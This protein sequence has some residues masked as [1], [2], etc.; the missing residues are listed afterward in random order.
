M[1]HKLRVPDE[2]AQVIGNLHPA[3]KRKVRAA[4]QA[5][6]EEPACGKAL[7][8]ELAGLRSYRFGRF[9]F[10]YRVAADRMVEVAAI[11]PRRRIYEETYR[12]LRGENR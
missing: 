11:G 10:V 6:V 5:I 3:V 4:L 1:L 8:E 9:R 2:L 12:K 7:K